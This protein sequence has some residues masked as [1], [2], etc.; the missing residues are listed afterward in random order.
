MITARGKVPS[1]DT[2]EII[3]ITSSSTRKAISF[4]A[5]FKKNKKMKLIFQKKRLKN[6]LPRPN[7]IYF[8]SDY[9]L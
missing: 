6:L 4:F 5:D 2:I 3:I 8:T 9:K 1:F 7:F